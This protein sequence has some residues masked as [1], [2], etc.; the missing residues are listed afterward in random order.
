MVGRSDSGGFYLYGN[1]PT[2]AVDFAAHHAL[3][4][5]RLG[6][7]QLAIHPNCGTSLLTSAL[8]ASAVAFSAL[9]GIGQS[10][11]RERLSRLP[12]AILGTTMA[13]IVAQPVGLAAQKHVTTLGDPGTMEIVSIQRLRGGANALHRLI[14][15]D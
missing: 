7:H 14:T 15:R 5:L 9:M 12:L 4:R 11:W 3:E 8:F 2:E 6:E 1:V 13:L 10:R